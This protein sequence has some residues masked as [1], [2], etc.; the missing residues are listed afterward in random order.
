LFL[1]N[2]L[3]TILFLLYNYPLSGGETK[4]VLMT[5]ELLPEAETATAEAETTTVEAAGTVTAEDSEAVTAAPGKC[6]K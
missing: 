5:E 3:Y 4:W 1:N 2:K 6:I